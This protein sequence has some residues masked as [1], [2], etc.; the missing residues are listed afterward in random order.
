VILWDYRGHGLSTAPEDPFTADQS[1]PR[2]ARDLQTVLDDIG[3]TRPAVLLGHSMGCQ[4]ILEYHVQQPDQVA[5]LVPMFGTYGRALD[6]FMGFAASRDAFRVIR[7]I[8]PLLDRSAFRMML[9]LYASPLA[10]AFSRWSGLVDRYRAGRVDMQHY[11]EHLQQMDPRVFLRTVE[12]MA[13]HDMQAHLARIDCPVLVF[14]GRNDLFTPVAL[15]ERMA[16]AIPDAE[17]C[18]LEEGSHAAIV[19][20]PATINLR[21]DRFLTDKCLQPSA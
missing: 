17:L 7:R 18:I 3:E 1:I 21:I 2:L 19:E 14:G 8:A 20:H 5:A 4:V 11:M 6:T 16:A 9:P 15:S 13:D 12:Q 10:F